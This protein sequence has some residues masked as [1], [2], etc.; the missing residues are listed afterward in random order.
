MKKTLRL[1]MCATILLLCGTSLVG[2]KEKAA[3]A[4]VEESQVEEQTYLTAV[5]DYLVNEIGR[6]YSPGDVCIPCP[7]VVSVDEGN[8]DDVLVWGDFWVFNYQI[9]GDTLKTVSGGDHPGL[10]H[11]QK[12]DS[13][14]VVK[15]FDAV[16]NGA[17]N[18][19]SAKRI[20][21]DHYDEYHAFNSDQKKREE[22]RALFISH[23]VK[24][25]KL[26]VT[27]YQDYGW[28]AVTLPNI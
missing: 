22:A 27:M 12:T 16:V 5:N 13:G 28:P 23:F 4:T 15:S 21:G 6:Y 9:A 25:N 3:E 11:V 7:T 8:P 10:M 2:C 14:F 18:M 1:W 24:E 20:F 26:P 19:E 17:G